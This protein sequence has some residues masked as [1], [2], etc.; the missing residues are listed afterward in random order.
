FRKNPYCMDWYYM[1]MDH[2]I[3]GLGHTAFCRFAFCLNL[4]FF[5]GIDIVSDCTVISLSKIGGWGPFNSSPSSGFVLTTE[6]RS[7]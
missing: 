3:F 7:Q 6:I 2:I 5:V 4:R 1:E